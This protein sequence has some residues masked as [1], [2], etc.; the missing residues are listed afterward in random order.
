MPSGLVPSS[1]LLTREGWGA[2][3]RPR[4]TSRGGEVIE[5][6]EITVHSVVVDGRLTIK[7]DTTPETPFGACPDEPEFRCCVDI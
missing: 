5:P 4:S 2:R 6:T 3:S 1:S 7:I